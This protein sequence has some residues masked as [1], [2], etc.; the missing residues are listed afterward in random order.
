MKDECSG[1]YKLLYYISISYMKYIY[2]AT[3]NLKTKAIMKRIYDR[4]T[5]KKTYKKG[6]VVYVLDTA[7]V[8][9]KCRQLS[10]NLKGPGLILEV[11]SPYLYK[12]KLRGKDSIM[13]H[14]ILKLCKDRQLPHWIRKNQTGTKDAGD[15]KGPNKTSTAFVGDLI[16]EPL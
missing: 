13:N 4:R 15:P 12:V 6:D 3:A 7:A 8:K 5:V 11:L 10:A 16:T 14:D 9:G 2:T 1:E